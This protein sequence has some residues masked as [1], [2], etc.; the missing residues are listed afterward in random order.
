VASLYLAR[1]QQMPLNSNH[2]RNELEQTQPLSRVMT[3]KVNRL[4]AW[5]KD[6]TVSAN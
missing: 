3:E 1:E 2:I 4:R 5:A 6:R